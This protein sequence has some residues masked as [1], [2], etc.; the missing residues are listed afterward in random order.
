MWFFGAIYGAN[1]ALCSLKKFLY[2]P[3][4]KNTAAFPNTACVLPMDKVTAEQ[5]KLN[6]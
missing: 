1:N 4:W 6:G 3:R 5:N 2:L